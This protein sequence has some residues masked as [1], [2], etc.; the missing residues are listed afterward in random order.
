LFAN[1]RSHYGTYDQTGLVY[2][3]NDLDSN[4]SLER[5]LR[6]GYWFS[7][8]QSSISSTFNIATP[9]RESSDAGFRLAAP[10]AQWM[11]DRFIDPLTGIHTFSAD[12]TEIASLQSSGWKEEGYAWSLLPAAGGESS[13]IAE[14]HRLYNPNS[15]DH[16]HTLN[17]AEVTSAKNLGYLYEGVAGRALSIPSSGSTGSTVVQRFYRPS[18][19][20]HFYTASSAEAASLPGLGFVS[21]GPAWMF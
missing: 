14:V 4:S 20:E 15:K 21:E 5:G 7:A 2:Q 16:L 13:T 9:N 8:G 18:S 1:S 10:E 19:G 17:D 12:S 11:F 6:G 3:W